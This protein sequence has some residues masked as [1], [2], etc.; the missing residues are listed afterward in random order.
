MSRHRFTSIASR[1]LVKAALMLILSGATLVARAQL[2][3]FDY[4]ADAMGGAFSLALYA[5]TRAYADAASSAAFDE[6]RRLDRMLSNYRPDSEWSEVNRYAATRGVRVSQEL[7]AL[8]SACLEYSR[9]SEGAFDITVGPLM[10]AW[11]FYDGSEKAVDDAAL[12]EARASVGYTHVS[13]DP[14]ECIVRFN[15]AGVEL[16]PGGIGKGY[17]VDRMVAVLK[18]SGIQG[19][20]VSAAGS[21]LFAL[22]AP[23]DQEGWQVNIHDQNLPERT[24][25]QL[26]LKDES[27]TTSGVSL[28]FVRVD[29]KAYGHIMD[30]RTGLPARGV[31]LVSVRAP[32]ALDGEAWAKAFFV[33]GRSWSVRHI[34]SGFQVFFCAEEAGRPVCGWLP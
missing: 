15:R 21:S 24:S 28:K 16:D 11:G 19:A 4:S 7:F 18:R 22:G 3:R 32:S 13:L 5:P 31:S 33:N 29:G 10:K 14:G 26:V 34:P 27:L 9:L 6:L 30:P 8:L 17:A 2:K 20:L 25:I 1:S 23:P 12:Q